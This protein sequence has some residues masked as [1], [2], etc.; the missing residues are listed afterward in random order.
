MNVE[1]E[2]SIQVHWYCK[3]WNMS[4][5]LVQH[6]TLSLIMIELACIIG[7]TDGRFVNFVSNENCF[8]C[9]PLHQ[10]IFR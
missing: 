3:C 6:N 2:S 8:K 7:L 9:Y 1:T 10:L 5:P 4:F